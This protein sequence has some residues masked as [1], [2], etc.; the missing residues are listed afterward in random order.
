MSKNGRCTSL[1]A[2]AIS[3]GNS[4]TR[5]KF[6]D[7]LGSSANIE[8][9]MSRNLPAVNTF[10]NKGEADRQTLKQMIDE[11]ERV[12]EWKGLAAVLRKATPPIRLS[13][14]TEPWLRE[15]YQDEDWEE[16]SMVKDL[17]EIATRE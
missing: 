2:E 12:P 13:S 3:A 16:R 10:L 4:T 7:Y 1:T 9:L 14:G 6:I 11:L 15:L 8:D 17:G 5:T